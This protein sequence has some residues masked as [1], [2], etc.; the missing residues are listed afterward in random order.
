[1][2][3]NGTLKIGTRGSPLAIWQAEAVR[4]ELVDAHPHLAEPMIEIKVVKTTGDRVLDRPLSEIGGKGLFT[5]ELDRALLD[6]TVDLAVHSMKDV[7]TWLPEGIELACFLAREDPRD[8]LVTAT[9]KVLEDLPGC[10]VVGTTSL[11]R[12]AQILNRFPHLDVRTFRGN[13]QTRLRKLR[14]GEA[15]ATLLALAGLKRLGLENIIT[16]ILEPEDM[17]PAV[18]QG[19]LGVA[20]RNSDETLKSLLAPLDNLP[21]RQEVTAERAML[22]VLDGSC[23]TPIA[24]LGRRQPDGR[25]VLHGLVAWPDGSKVHSADLSGASDQAMALGRELGRKL[26][27]AAGEAFFTALAQ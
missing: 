17:L 25:L 16:A 19:A 27:C 1:V 15:D 12:Q 26:R 18:G 24:G 3:E 11:R 5:K 13:V 21:C 7:P 14:D 10:G 22:A 2:S 4:D 8:T 23:K 6:G 9:G 20:C